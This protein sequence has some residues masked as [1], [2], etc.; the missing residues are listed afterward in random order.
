M[1]KD[2]TGTVNDTVKKAQKVADDFGKNTGKVINKSAR[3]L[4]NANPVNLVMGAVIN[5]QVKNKKDLAKDFQVAMVHDKELG[6]KLGFS[7]KQVEQ[8]EKFLGIKDKVDE[9]KRLDKNQKL[10]DKTMPSKKELKLHEE[11]ALKRNQKILDKISPKDARST[12]KE[13]PE[14]KIDKHNQPKKTGLDISQTKKDL[15][16]Q[17]A[18]INIANADYRLAMNN[19]AFDE[20]S[21]QAFNARNAKETM[22]MGD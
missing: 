15:I 6:K 18:M 8:G 9:A 14:P 10:L 16:K 12:S 22:E 11:K 4:A 5:N 3:N 21:R 19:A 2:V 20:A 7:P 1:Q 17:P 13:K